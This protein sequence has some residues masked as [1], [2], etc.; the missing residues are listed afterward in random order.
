MATEPTIHTVQLGD[1]GE[2][3]AE[4]GAALAPDQRY[5]LACGHRRAD[6]RIPFMEILAP[7]AGQAAGPPSGPGTAP[8]GAA[9]AAVPP[10][11]VQASRQRSN[12]ILLAGLACLLVALGIGVLLGQAGADNGSSQP[13]VV[14]VS[15]AGAAPA[16]AAATGA[17]AGAAAGSSAAKKSGSASKGG[18]SSSKSSSSGSTASSAPTNPQVQSLDTGDPAQNQKNSA[19][20]PKTIVSGGKPPPKAKPKTGG[21]DATI[22]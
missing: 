14:S 15:G 17:A 12:L 20:L 21:F 5:C 7:A 11:A 10:A 3:C 18:S 22:G 1:P 4:C 6:A 9:G 19:K 8:A 2:R 16:A 13:Q